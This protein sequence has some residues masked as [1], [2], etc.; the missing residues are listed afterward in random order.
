MLLGV[1]LVIGDGLEAA[2]V[3]A[4]HQGVEAQQIRIRLRRLLELL[5][6]D[7]GRIEVRPGWL[8]PD[9]FHFH[10]RLVAAEAVP[11][12]VVDL[13]QAAHRFVVDRGEESVLVAV[14]LVPED[15]VHGLGG[16]DQ[17]RDHP[18]LLVTQ[19]GKIGGEPEGG[20]LVE[21][22]PGGG[23]LFGGRRGRRGRLAGGLA[24]SHG[25]PEEQ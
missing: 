14:G 5:L 7:V 9:P 17:D 2:L 18:P 4:P 11:G 1:G 12:T 24:T 20:V 21:E 23:V 19:H 3:A 15:V 10:E 13:D 8:R 16:L 6:G 25:E 22:L